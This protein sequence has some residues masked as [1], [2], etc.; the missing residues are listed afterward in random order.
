MPAL[1]HL[2]VSSSSCQGAA[3]TRNQDA[4]LAA[5]R[6]GVF[7]VA[8]GIGGLPNG[9]WASRSIVQALEDEATGTSLPFEQQ[10]RLAEDAVLR[11]NRSLYETGCRA[12]PPFTMGSTIA[13]VLVG[14]DRAACL[15][16]GDSRIYLHHEGALYLLTTDHVE[17]IPFGAAGT[18]RTV[19]TRA[20]GS[21]PRLKLDRVTVPFAPGD[22]LLLCSDGVFNVLPASL[23]R[24]LIAARGENLADR[25]VTE[26]LDAG[27]QDD[28]TAVT[29]FAPQVAP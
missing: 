22:T 29:I 1:A 13:L 12:A 26:A 19:L 21:A 11:T 27:T 10:V 2:T 17:K 9:D 24:D 23:L 18:S 16:A 28:A 5:P 8:D 6:A 25:I 7:A 3:R 4:F 20:V 14:H 15:W